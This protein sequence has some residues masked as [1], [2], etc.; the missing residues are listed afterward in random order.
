MLD[1]LTRGFNE[2]ELVH[3]R[4]VFSHLERLKMPKKTPGGSFFVQ[5]SLLRPKKYKANHI[6][7]LLTSEEE[8]VHLFRT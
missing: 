3:A 6:R 4:P 5:F 2:P 1:T 7:T 8:K